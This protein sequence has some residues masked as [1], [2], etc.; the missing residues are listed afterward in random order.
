MKAEEMFKKMGWEKKTTKTEMYY[1]KLSTDGIHY[2]FITFNLLHK[3]SYFFN[4]VDK[5]DESVTMY[6]DKHLI[7]AINKQI[8][9]LG[10]IQ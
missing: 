9:E 5:E 2:N 3:K 1:Q 4:E 6:F 7:K 10:W 8:I